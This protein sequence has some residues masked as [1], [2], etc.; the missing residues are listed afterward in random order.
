MSFRAS[1]MRIASSASPASNTTNPTLGA[2]GDVGSDQEF[3]FDDEDLKG[4]V[5]LGV[6]HFKLL[7][8]NFGEVMLAP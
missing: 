7:S 4:I 5:V 8:F 3:V 2:A 1:R 6:G